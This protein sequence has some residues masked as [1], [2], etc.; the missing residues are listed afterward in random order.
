MATITLKGNPI[1]TCGNLPEKGTQAPDFKLLRTDL[2]E[3]TLSDFAGKKK[4]LNIFPSVDTPTCAMSV[5]KFNEAATGTNGAVVINISADL[6]FAQKRFCGSEGIEN[7]EALSTFR[8]SFAKDYGLE[9]S[10]GPIAGLCSRAVVIL[11]E[12]NKVIHTEQ[13]QEIA[14]EPNYEAALAALQ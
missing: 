5:R 13:V 11:D 10:E 4:V 9:I 8:S 2:S 1:K 12:D 14:D 3:V 7:A 6:P